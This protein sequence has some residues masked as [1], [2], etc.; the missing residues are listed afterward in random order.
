M[1]T[2]HKR[3]GMTFTGCFVPLFTII[4]FPQTRKTFEEES[5]HELADDFS[6]RG[7]LQPP[8][9]GKLSKE[10]FIIYKKTFEEIYGMTLPAIETYPT[11]EDYYYCLIAGERRY[12]GHVWLWSR[13][14]THCN[15]GAVEKDRP[16]A[17]GQCYR[18]HFGDAMIEIRACL[19]IDPLDAK[20]IQFRENNH[21]R[22]PMHEVADDYQTYFRYLKKFKKKLTFKDFAQIVGVSTSKVRNA[23]WFCELPE[24]VQDA[25]RQKKIP[26]SHAL[27]FKKI[28]D[29]RIE[30][31]KKI[32]FMEDE[33]ALLLA[34]PRTRLEDF[35]ARI[36]GRLETL[37][38]GYG[39]LFGP[40]EERVSQKLIRKIVGKELIPFITILTQYL[41]T[42]SDKDKR[43]IIG[44]GKIYS[45]GSPNYQVPLIAHALKQL[46]PEFEFTKKQIAHIAGRD[47]GKSSVEETRVLKAV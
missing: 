37:T 5:L 14:C 42:L 16:L 24:R 38:A 8:I 41:K 46:F 43:N 19:E 9:V 21:E 18:A 44:K 33:L 20:S 10:K 12:R 40:L 2:L 13:G 26:H 36:E 6:I 28:F 47:F 22:P 35:K 3:K 15:E 7:L 32:A 4:T 29:S 39:S 27:V 11:Y 45:E 17:E 23:L 31:K 25:V 1:S 30:E 34:K